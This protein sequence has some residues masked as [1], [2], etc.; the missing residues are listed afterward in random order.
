ML[1]RSARLLLVVAALAAVSGA[2]A[3]TARADIPIQPFDG[4]A[5]VAPDATRTLGPG[6]PDVEA[7]SLLT[8]YASG[9]C[10]RFVVDVLVPTNTSGGAHYHDAFSIFG[11]I[12]SALSPSFNLGLSSSAC[13]TYEGY[14]RVYRKSAYDGAFVSV[15]GGRTTGAWIEDGGL[16]GPHC[17]PVKAP[18]YVDLPV[19]QPPSRMSA[20]YRVTASA[21][22]YGINAAVRVGAWHAPIIY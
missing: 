11:T 5:M 18:G 3:G 22:I 4:C 1:R 20:V 10:S 17:T 21:K 9:L 6:V 2:A 16:L 8:S 12:H 14:V 7:S 19:F 13:A 15:G